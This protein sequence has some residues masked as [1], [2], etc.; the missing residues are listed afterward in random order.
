MFM[1][2]L[3]IGGNGFL[4]KHVQ[5]LLKDHE[6]YSP[7]HSEIDWATGEGISK[8]DSYNPEVVIHLLAI[9]GGLPFCMENRVRMGIENLEINANVYRYLINSKPKRLITI[10]SGCEYPG[11]KKGILKEEDIG[12]GKLHQSV[13]HYGYTK[14]IQLELCK[15]LREEFGMEYEHIVLANMYGP[16]DIF[17]EKRSHVVGALIYKFVKAMKENSQL[18]LLGTGRAVRDLIYVKDVAHMIQ[19]LVDR[20]KSTNQPLNASTG[21][22]TS[23]KELA[24]T[25][26]NILDFKEEIKWGDESQ[27]GS[28]IKYLSSERTEQILKWKPNTDLK[29]GL[30]ET[31]DWYL[32]ENT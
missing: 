26:S 20:E 5:D 1:K 25:I 2:I 4:G 22:G 10:G 16:G 6:V 7:T 8:L 21:T 11:Y 29:N 32:N 24:E 18:Q 14:L 27:D 13:E 28:L 9:Y 12:N 15:A 23:I 30:K 3:M 19:M 17:D 31:I